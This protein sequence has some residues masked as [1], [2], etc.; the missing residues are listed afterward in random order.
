MK[1]IN[2]KELAEKSGKTEMEVYE[3]IRDVLVI[4]A[5]V[6]GEPQRLRITIPAG[7]KQ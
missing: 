7:K 3:F 2:L 1:T 6:Y 5:E 4:K